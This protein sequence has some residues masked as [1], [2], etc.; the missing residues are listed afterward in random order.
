MKSILP[1]ILLIAIPC[2]VA[3]LDISGYYENTLVPEYSDD[4]NEHILDISKLRLDFSS[5][6]GSNELQFKANINLIELHAGAKY[7]LT[8]YLPASV[9]DTLAAWDIPAE[10]TLSQSR[11]FL[12]NA[13]LS[14][15]IGSVSLRLGRQQLSWGP[16]YSFNPT[17]LFHKK[18]LLDPTYEKEGVT[19]LRLDY[20]WGIGGQLAGI[21]VPGAKLD[22]SGYAVRLATHIHSIGYDLA[23]TAHQVTSK[24][25]PW[26]LTSADA[27]S[28]RGSGWKVTITR[29]KLRTISYAP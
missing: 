19:A 18:E 9:A 23:L 20:R 13:Y 8:P 27:S 12:D 14:W 15:K 11:I 1:I 24:D 10:M 22:R 4:L 26:D 6:S 5:G 29:W 17:D 28:V 3:A 2:Y 21:I 16:A 7:D 25:E